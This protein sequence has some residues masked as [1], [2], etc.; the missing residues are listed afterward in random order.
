MRFWP[1]LRPAVW[2]ALIGNPLTLRMLGEVAAAADSRLPD[3]RAELFD[4]AC[5][6]MLEE[7]NP[8]P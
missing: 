4:R 2:N 5:R 3:T 6:I 8:S 1:A 7:R